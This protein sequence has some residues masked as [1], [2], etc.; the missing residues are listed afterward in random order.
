MA[1]ACSSISRE[2]SRDLCLFLDQVQHSPGTKES[3]R[4]R[5]F[6]PVP[7]TETFSL[8]FVVPVLELVL[9]A[10]ITKDQKAFFLVVIT[11]IQLT[12]HNSTRFNTCTTCWM[13]DV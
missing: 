1:T 8:G 6:Y 5:L 11:C 3:L 12:G 4:Y 13:R 9:K 10:H 2:K 7:K